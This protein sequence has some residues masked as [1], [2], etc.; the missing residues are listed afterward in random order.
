MKIHEIPSRIKFYECLIYLVSVNPDE[1]PWSR[2]NKHCLFFGHRQGEKIA[3]GQ[4]KCFVLDLN[5]LKDIKH[6]RVK[7]KERKLQFIVIPM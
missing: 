1:F 5:F 2:G 7:L 6:F 3:W 4:G